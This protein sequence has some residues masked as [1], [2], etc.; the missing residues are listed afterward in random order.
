[1]N[2]KCVRRYKL[3]FSLPE[4]VAALKA[5]H[6]NDILIQSMPKIASGFEVFGECEGKKM[7][8]LFVEWEKSTEVVS[9]TPGNRGAIVKVT[10][11][12]V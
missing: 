2:S 1:M 4:I 7:L 9:G 5:A 12:E 3:D 11:G 10:D 6:P 8:T